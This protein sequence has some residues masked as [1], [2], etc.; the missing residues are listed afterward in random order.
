[1]REGRVLSRIEDP[2]VPP[3]WKDDRIA[4]SPSAKVYAV[5]CDPAGRLRYRYHDNHR[6][7]KEREKFEP[8]RGLADRLPEVRRCTSNHPGRKRLGREKVFARF[9]QNG[10]NGVF[11]HSQRFDSMSTLA[12]RCEGR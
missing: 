8:V 6:E 5:G 11:T 10:P 4:R 2:K 7:R 9:A 12:R 1:V 3:D